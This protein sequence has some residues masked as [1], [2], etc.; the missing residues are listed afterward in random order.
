MRYYI[1]KNSKGDTIG[2]VQTDGNPGK[3]AIEVSK[4]EFIEMGFYSGEPSYNE[5]VEPEIPN[6]KA[7]EDMWTQLAQAI[8][9]GV[10]EV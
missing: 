4:E 2:Y 8:K 6:T 3:N 9:E 1:Y 5:P 10:N 7:G